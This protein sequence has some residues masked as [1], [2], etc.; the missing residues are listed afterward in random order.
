MR[1]SVTKSRKLT[2]IGSSLALR[3]ALPATNFPEGSRVS[4]SDADKPVVLISFPTEPS[5]ALLV[6]RLGSEGIGAEMSGALTSAFRASVAGAVQVLVRP[7]D[8]ARARELL[9][10]WHVH[11][12]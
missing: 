9:A 7:K 2:R 6:G 10:A 11:G 5:A 3:I 8:A 12:G 4:S 1:S